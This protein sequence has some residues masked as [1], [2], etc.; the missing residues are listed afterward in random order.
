[1]IQGPELS[2]LGGSV[3]IEKNVNGASGI[4]QCSRPDWCHLISKESAI[5]GKDSPDRL[6]TVQNP[7][8][9]VAFTYVI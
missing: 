4:A 3:H 2:N 1:M 6:Y 8:L 9:Q 7:L 5:S